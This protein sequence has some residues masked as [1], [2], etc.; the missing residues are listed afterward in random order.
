MLYGK[1]ENHGKIRDSR[2]Q[3]LN[4]IR[5]HFVYRNSH[6]EMPKKALKLSGVKPSRN[7]NYRAI[8]ANNVTY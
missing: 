5:V 8:M 6:Y 4:Y 3:V 7:P 1:G 2:V